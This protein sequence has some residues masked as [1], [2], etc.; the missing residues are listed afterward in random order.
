MSMEK[1]PMADSNPKM[2]MSNDRLGLFILFALEAK[3]LLHGKQA[4]WQDFF[5]REENGGALNE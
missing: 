2:K 1:G 4:L 3:V 5:K